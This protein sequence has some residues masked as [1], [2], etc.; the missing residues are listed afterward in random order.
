MSVFHL[1]Y[2]ICWC[3]YFSPFNGRVILNC[4]NKTDFIYS[5]TDSHLG[6]L[7][8]GATVN[9]PAMNIGIQVFV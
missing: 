7:H 4:I 2:P 6:S 1:S 9:Y 8:F 5:S 3:K